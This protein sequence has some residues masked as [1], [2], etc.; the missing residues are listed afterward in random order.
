MDLEGTA[1]GPHT[2]VRKTADQLR[3]CVGAEALAA[4]GEHNNVGISLANGE[5]QAGRF[6]CARGPGEER[7]SVG[8]KG[9]N[10]FGS[11]IIGPI[12]HYHH[13]QS[14]EVLRKQV[15][16]TRTDAS[17]FVVDRHNHRYRELIAWP[18]FGRRF[19]GES[20]EHGNQ[21]RVAEEGINQAGRAC[22]EKRL[23]QRFL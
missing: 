1:H 9:G 14:F 22:P 8:L 21:T 23:G 11:S 16:K 15:F 4:I 10:L 18:D 19:R 5:I 6:S 2:W 7:D 13:F 3:N 17:P 20:R 12:V